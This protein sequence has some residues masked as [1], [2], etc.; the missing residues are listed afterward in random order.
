MDSHTRL[1]SAEHPY[2]RLHVA[3]AFGVLYVVWG[4]TYLAIRVALDSMAPAPAAALRF[5]LAGTVMLSCAR[6][7]RRSL[8]V[9]WRELKSLATIG[10]LLLVGGNG[11][12]VWSEEYV[13][14]GFAAL[15]I[16]TMPLW[17]CIASAFLKEGE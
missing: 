4:S 3:A 16:A 13:T 14:S 7:T 8:S 17:V 9:S 6:L 12:V 11:L 1:G 10:I 5:L 2:F 15:I